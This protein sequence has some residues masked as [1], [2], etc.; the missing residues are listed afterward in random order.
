[1]PSRSLPIRGA[2]NSLMGSQ[3]TALAS[4]PHRRLNP[5]TGEW[6]LVSPH[7]TQ[8][9]W[10]GRREEAAPTRPPPYD[11]TC[12]LCP[13]NARA[14]GACNPRYAGTFVFDND[15]AALLPT[16]DPWHLDQGGLLVAEGARGICRVICFSPRH[17]AHLATMELEAARGVIDVWAEQS[18]ELA[19]IPWVQHIQIFEN[20]GSMMGA[21]NPHPHCQVWADE[22]IP[23]EPGKELRRLHDY[24][25]RHG[26]CLLCDYLAM[27]RADGSRLVSENEHF[28]ALV[29]FWAVWPFEVLVLPRAHRGA[30][31]DLAADERTA[32]AAA[33]TDVVRRYDELFATPFPYSMG[34]HQRPAGRTYPEWHLHAHYYPPLLRSATVRKFM[35]GYEMLAQPQRDLTP[36]AAAARLRAPA[37]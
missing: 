27:E 12:Y 14:S 10:L 36:E 25:E 13:G 8:R 7:R 31:T 34:V 26:T 22:A 9:P 19:A 21:S 37:G 15:F 6:V 17:D 1:M 5:L 20:R 4:D 29:P 28:T 3:A 23:V 16:V 18:A 33:L 35:V 24:R 30:L 11:P 32:L 2:V